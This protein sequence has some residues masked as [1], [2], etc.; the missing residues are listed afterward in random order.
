MPKVAFVT[1]AARGVGRATAVALAD[2]GYDLLV[3]DVCAPIPGCP[4]PLATRD[5]LEETA[6]R[7]RHL[8]SRVVA[9]VTDVRRPDEVDEAA[10]R[11]RTELGPIDLLVNNAGLVGPAGVPAHELDE[12]AWT[13][14]VEVDLGGVWRC[15]KAVL[16]D[17]VSRRS[18]AIVNVAST[19]GIVAFPHFANYVAAKHG[20]VGLTRALALDYAGYSIRVNAVCPTS[21]RDE[22]DLASGMLHG[23]A[24]MLG[25]GIEDYEALSLPNHPLGTL[26]DAADVAAAIVWLSSD[27]AA[28]ITGAILPVD[29]GFTSR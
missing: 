24:G 17:M 13:V 4:Y 29:A 14:V 26:V 22:P 20:V 2:A 10:Q 8:G 3:T 23:V 25:V 16:P 12:D 1:G 11:G 27:A 18:G 21:V 5:D 19:A 7:C 15:S 28:K 6:E 9:T